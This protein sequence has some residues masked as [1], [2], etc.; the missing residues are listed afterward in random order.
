MLP[1]IVCMHALSA[2]CLLTRLFVNQFQPGLNFSC[3]RT[4]AQGSG[5]K[6][7]HPASSSPAPARAP[8]TASMFGPWAV[9]RRL[10]VTCYS[11]RSPIDGIKTLP[12]AFNRAAIM[13]RDSDALLFSIETYD[14]HSFVAGPLHHAPSYESVVLLLR[15]IAFSPAPTSAPPPTMIQLLDSKQPACTMIQEAPIILRII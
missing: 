8:A 14:E 4:Q 1:S 10:Y 9:W 3:A 11:L 2:P 5:R 12:M 13:R 6:A 15:R 7:C